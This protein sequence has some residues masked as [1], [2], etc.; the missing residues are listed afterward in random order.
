MGAGTHAHPAPY[1]RLGRQQCA[2][3]EDLLPVFG[4]QEARMSYAD[5][6]RV[7]L[8]PRGEDRETE[9]G[10]PE[11]ARPNGWR[12]L[13]PAAAMIDGRTVAYPSTTDEVLCRAYSG[14]VRRLST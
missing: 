9:S 14:V 12:G 7:A 3:G 10:V 13:A 1:H 6:K 5:V 8:D 4:F 11:Q 2:G